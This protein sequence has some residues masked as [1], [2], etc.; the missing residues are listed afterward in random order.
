MTETIYTYCEDTISD[1]H[2]DA[3]GFRPSQG[4]WQRWDQASADEKQAEWDSLVREM[5][6]REREEKQE[7]QQCIAAL[8]DRIANLMECGARNREM[9]IRWLDQAYESN[10]DTEFLEYCL[11]VPF[12][13]LRGVAKTQQ[14]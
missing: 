1:L 8:E 13:Y 5:E 2:K 9:A 11:G 14:A 4:F 6:N 12:G 3:Y 10:G 7:Q